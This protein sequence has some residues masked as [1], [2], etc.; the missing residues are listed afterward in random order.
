MAV[1]SSEAG[2]FW[3]DFLRTL[4]RRGLSGAGASGKVQ[5]RIVSA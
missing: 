3:R 1:G 5:R 2:P 4:A